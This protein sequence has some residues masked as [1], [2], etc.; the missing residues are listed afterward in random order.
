MKNKFF[1]FMG[2]A[3]LA[4]LCFTF[5]SC[6]DDDE[7]GGGNTNTNANTGLSG[8]YAPVNNMTEAVRLAKSDAEF[9]G[10]AI[11][12]PVGGGFTCY[13]FINGNTVEHLWVNLYNTYKPNTVCTTTMAGMTVYVVSE[14]VW[15]SYTY[16]LKNDILY[17][18]NG[19]VTPFYAGSFTIPTEYTF[20]KL[21]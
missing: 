7:K 20:T 3:M 13:H 16:E 2:I 11:Q 4:M 17:I 10:T 1:K 12:W 15:G 8:Y 5:S 14:Y 18:S 9:Y 21:N 6:G 19:T